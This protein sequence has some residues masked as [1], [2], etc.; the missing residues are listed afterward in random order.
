MSLFRL[1]TDGVP[2][3]KQTLA[4]LFQIFLSPEEVSPASSHQV[5]R[6]TEAV[7][8]VIYILRSQP[9]TKAKEK[10]TFEVFTAALQEL[11]HRE[12]QLPALF[13]AVRHYSQPDLIPKP[14][15]RLLA[16]TLDLL[17]QLLHCFMPDSSGKFPQLQLLFFN[18]LFTASAA[19]AATA[20]GQPPQGLGDAKTV[21]PMDYF[22]DHNV[23]PTCHLVRFMWVLVYNHTRLQLSL[24]RESRLKEFLTAHMDT[25]APP[26][27]RATSRS[28]RLTEALQVAG[29]FWSFSQRGGNG[30]F[31]NEATMTAQHVWLKYVLDCE[32]RDRGNTHR[33]LTYLMHLLSQ[34]ENV[35]AG[36][37]GMG[38]LFALFSMDCELF[39][40]L[41]KYLV[42][43]LGVLP[44]VCRLLHDAL[45][46]SIKV[47]ALELLGILC[48]YYPSAVGSD[49]K[50]IER[51]LS[52]IGQCL[53]VADNANTPSLRT[54]GRI[55]EQSAVLALGSAVHGSPDAQ[56]I[57]AAMEDGLFFKQVCVLSL[58]FMRSHYAKTGGG[59]TAFTAVHKL[60]AAAILGVSMAARSNQHETQQLVATTVFGEGAAS[61]QPA[62]KRGQAIAPENNVLATMFHLLSQRRSGFYA[63]AQVSTLLL[64]SIGDVVR[65]N[66]AVVEQVLALDGVDKLLKVVGK[67]SFA[68]RNACI[69]RRCVEVCPKHAHFQRNAGHVAYARGSPLR[70]VILVLQHGLRIASAQGAPVD[71]QAGALVN[72]EDYH[73]WVRACATAPSVPDSANN[74]QVVLHW[75]TDAVALKDNTV[76]CELPFA[77]YHELIQSSPMPSMLAPPG[78]DAQSRQQPLPVFGSLHDLGLNARKHIL[79]VLRR[80]LFR[81]GGQSLEGLSQEVLDESIQINL[82]ARVRDTAIYTECLNAAAGCLSGICSALEYM[83]DI[84]EPTLGEEVFRN[85]LDS[86]RMVPAGVGVVLLSCLKW[87]CRGN[88]GRYSTREVF[89]LMQERAEHV[90]A[91]QDPAQPTKG[92]KRKAA[93]SVKAAASAKRPKRK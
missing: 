20:Q 25:R 77:V 29:L 32:Q 87:V 37:V 39:P 47:K 40:E 28:V 72:E 15:V 91:P 7:R 52:L 79:E 2:R 35:K 67:M 63:P 5:A 3:T 36:Y 24:L 93:A 34:K 69:L 60:T 23:V 92:T 64:E 84:E 85:L 21:V 88:P 80:A 6:M 76:Y 86:V 62:S 26:S 12:S 8:A 19:P 81:S 11:R 4:L 48:Y 1:K 73:A 49:K 30:N 78:E 45:E 14:F 27:S 55:V 68:Y 56:A 59:G 43:Q 42:V 53:F 83:R 89:D 65:G 66:P 41:A 31:K 71:Y 33:P 10:E 13:S 17:T 44:H 9:L 75:A 58:S 57:L 50:S 46:P 54:P 90:P 70:G 18:L 22:F 38:A 51:T 74:P 82:A 16:V 61:G